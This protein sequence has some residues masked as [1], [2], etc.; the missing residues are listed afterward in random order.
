MSAADEDLLGST[1]GPAP[2]GP[3]MGPGNLEED[4]RN[5]AD[6]VFS[7][8]EM[9][10]ADDGYYRELKNAEEHEAR[11]LPTAAMSVCLVER[12]REKMAFN[13]CD[14][15]YVDTGAR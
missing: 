7:G 11:E 9:Y 1:R 10:T 5:E 3:P 6:A 8:D 12:G 2:L 14:H 4:V 13:G 15:G